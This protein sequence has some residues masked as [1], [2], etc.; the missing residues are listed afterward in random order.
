MN[1]NG[2]ILFAHHFK[3]QFI[4]YAVEKLIDYST[5]WPYNDTILVNNFLKDIQWIRAAAEFF[6]TNSNEKIKEVLN[7]FTWARKDPDYQIEV[8]QRHS[9]CY[10]AFIQIN[11]Y[12][13]LSVNN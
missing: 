8:F 10:H 13:T 2:M 6:R 4:D 11:L 7:M 3:S 12:L 1:N 9:N 5:K